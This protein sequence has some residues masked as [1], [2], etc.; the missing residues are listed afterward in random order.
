ML[1]KINKWGLSRR[2]LMHLCVCDCVCVCVCVLGLSLCVSARVLTASV[3]VYVCLC[4]FVC[5]CTCFLTPTEAHS[6]PACYK[7]FYSIIKNPTDPGG[8]PIE[9][10]ISFPFPHPNHLPFSFPFSIWARPAWAYRWGK[11]KYRPPA[12]DWECQGIVNTKLNSRLS[13]PRIHFHNQ[14]LAPVPRWDRRA[15]EKK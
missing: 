3:C 9:K 5:V 10:P 4:V 14:V 12:T 11:C 6:S 1:K 2:N 7:L 8:A 15:W 13:R